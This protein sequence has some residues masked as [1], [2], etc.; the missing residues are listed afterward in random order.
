MKIKAFSLMCCALL[1]PLSVRADVIVDW[2]RIATDVLVNDIVSQH[3]G[4]ASRT[5]AM[6]NLAMYDSFQVTSGG[7]TFFNYSGQLSAP[8]GPTSRD[9]AAIQA[10]YTVLSSGYPN[11][12]PLLNPNLA[13]SLAALPDGPEKE[14]GILLGTM[15]GNSIVQRRAADGYDSNEQFMPTGE[16]GHW[17]PDPYNNTQEAWGPVW[18]QVRPFSI[19]SGKQFTVAPMPDMTSP[20]YA[21]SFDEVKDLGSLTNSSRTPDQ[22]EIG[23]FW[24]YDR[25]G[26]GT[27]MRLYNR[28]LQT[29]AEQEQNTPEE[30]AEL[31]A[32][33][34]VAMA[35]AG[36]AAWN[37]KYDY[38]FWRPVAAIH[39][40]DLDGNPDTL[41]DPTWRPLGSPGADP[42]D[43][44]D[45]FT[46]PF[47]TYVSGHAT[48]GGA[49]FHTLIDFYG[50]D[51]LN[52]QGNVAFTLTSEELDGVERDFN[53]FTH[54]MQENGRSRV[55]LGVHFDFD[56]LR[57]QDLG[58]DVATYIAGRPFVAVPEPTT[59]MLLAIGLLAFGYRSVVARW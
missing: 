15:I 38:D 4:E 23:I 37:S 53:S 17:G 8:T 12:G 27:P 13:N 45:D 40:A 30:N 48:F 34:T 24:A 3:P 32:R 43:M 55:Y 11:E 49:L 51:Y 6:V 21:Q 14:N 20:E 59:A 28:V 18:G 31:F 1:V 42:N 46:P 7:Q 54:A 44:N 9:V 22:T 41:A 33:A 25:I 29:I 56:D 57:A 26:L 39:Q 35:D 10:A 36:I 47:P 2:N 52:G 58:I 50:T 5:M 16:I 19:N